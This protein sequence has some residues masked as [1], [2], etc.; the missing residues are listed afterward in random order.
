VQGVPLGVVA[1]PLGL[2]DHV[3]VDLAHDDQALYAD[4]TRVAHPTSVLRDA[5]GLVADVFGQ[6]QRRERADAH[7]APAVGEEGVHAELSRARHRVDG[8]GTAH[9]GGEG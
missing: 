5:R 2:D 6:V 7:P 3:A 9:L 1:C 8:E 4:T